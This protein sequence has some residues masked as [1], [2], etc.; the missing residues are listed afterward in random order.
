MQTPILLVKPMNITAMQERSDELLVR[1][2]DRHCDEPGIALRQ[3]NERLSSIALPFDLKTQLREL[4]FP[5]RPDLAQGLPSL[6][7]YFVPNSTQGSER[8][9]PP[10]P[11]HPAFLKTCDGIG[12]NLGCPLRLLRAMNA[13]ARLSEDDQVEPRAALRTSTQHLS[14]VEEL[15]WLTG[16][17]SISRS[18]RGG[19]F[20]GL[21]G[22]I[23]WAFEA[24]GTPILLEAK[25][26]M[27]DWPRLVDGD[28]FLKAGD[29]GFLSNATHKFPDHSRSFAIHVVGITTFGD[30]TEDVAHCIGREL[31]LKPQIDAVIIR[32]MR[33]VVHILALDDNLCIR[34]KDLRTLPCWREVPRYGVFFNIKE[35]DKRLAKQVQQAPQIC[36]KINTEYLVPKGTPLFPDPDPDAYKLD[37][38]SRGLDG[39]PHLRVIP[40]DSSPFQTG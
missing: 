32:D 30:I 10:D 28:S 12:L 40:N 36:S 21:R 38:P 18:R 1:L 9:V 34:L 19:R 15:L 4:P 39:E 16:W 20:P 31:E 25:F 35:R 6:I 27:S 17:N 26:R 13:L 7:Y 5:P 2:F 37:I 8:P 11:L 33:E 22:D 14:A 3:L 29:D 23:D 24:S